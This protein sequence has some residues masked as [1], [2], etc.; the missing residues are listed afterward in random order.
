MRA[1]R[2]ARRRARRKSLSATVSRSSSRRP[3]AMRPTTPARRG[4][5]PRPPRRRPAAGPGRGRG[6]RSVAP[7]SEPPPAKASLGT[8]SPAPTSSRSARRGP[9]KCAASWRSMASTGT[10][11]GVSRWSISVASSA[12]SDSLSSR[13]ARSSGW[14]RRRSTAAGRAGDQAGLRPAEQLVAAAGDEVGAGGE[15]LGHGRLGQP[16]D[17]GDQPVPRSAT[18][19]SRARGRG[20]PARRSRSR[21]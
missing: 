13:T 6:F 8:I 21:R 17:G 19:C 18:T 12:A 10:R 15:R 3:S 1:P 5:A 2:G 4:A 14:R 20:R 7:G 11:S 16:G 9:A